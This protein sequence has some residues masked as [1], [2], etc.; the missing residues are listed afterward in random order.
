MEC[1]LFDVLKVFFPP[2]RIIIVALGIS[3]S[4]TFIH[5][6]FTVLHIEI[7]LFD[8]L[9]KVFL[10]DVVCYAL[11]SLGGEFLLIELEIGVHTRGEVGHVLE[12]LVL[13][14]LR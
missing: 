8:S 12:F 3:S 1:L 9:L 2:E 4:L 13:L 6:S 5:I 7:P 10:V 11:R 14:F